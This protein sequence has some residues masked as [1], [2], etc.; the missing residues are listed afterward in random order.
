TAACTPT[1]AYASVSSHTITAT[2]NNSDGNFTS[3]KAT[4]LV[5]VVKNGTSTALTSAPNPQQA[6]GSVT[7]TATV[8]KST[9]TG[10][11]TGTVTF[12]SGTPSGSHTSLGNGTLN[13]S[14]VAT[15]STS[16]LPV[17]ADS[18]YAVYNGDT[19]FNPSTSPVITENIV[20]LPAAC[21]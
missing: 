5:Q 20:G 6:G 17:G 15:L 13:S 10:T 1:P 2:Y 19:N 14:G 9:G 11:P 3:P 16:T 7:L 21:T 12:F 18:L 8:T 4:S